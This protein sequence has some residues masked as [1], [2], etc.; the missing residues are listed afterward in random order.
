MDGQYIGSMDRQLISE[1]DP[2]LWLSRG[3]LEG[4]TESE[5]AAQGQALQSKYHMTEL[6][7]TETHS[8]CRLCKQFHEA[9]E[10]IISACPILA[11]KQ[12]REKHDSVCLATL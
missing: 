11:Q 8:T 6:L 1:E 2:F 9:V 3:D 5:I 4:E 12:D 10:H 7:Q